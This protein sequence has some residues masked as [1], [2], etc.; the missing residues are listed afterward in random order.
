MSKYLLHIVLILFI[1]N[2]CGT[3]KVAQNSP[4]QISKKDYPYI[5]KFHEG[6]RLKTKGR[7]EEAI[8][9]FEECLTIRQ[10]D[11]AV[12]YALSKLEFSKGN[13]EQSANYIVKA[14]EID[15]DN[16]WYIQEL[17]YM[18]YETGNFEKSVAAFEQLVEIEPRNVD[19]QYGYAEA[20]VRVGKT[21]KAIDALNKT[22]DQVGANPQLAIQ[23]YQLYM[24]L[25]KPEK[26]VS[27]LS[28]ARK[29]FPKD[30]QLIAKLVDHYY[31][32]G[33]QQK[34]VDML[35]ELVLADPDNGRAHL[36]LADVYL[37]KKDMTKAYEQLE[38]AFHSSDIDL[39]TK[40]KILITILESSSKI[41]EPVYKLVD[42]LIQ[43]HPTEAKAHSIRGDYL[44]RAEKDEAALLSYKEALKYDNSQFPIWNQVLIMEYQANDYPAL[45]ADSKECLTLFPSISVVYLLNGVSSNQLDKY[46][47]AVDALSVGVEMVVK[48]KTLEAEFY[49][50]M[51]TAYFGLKDFG[52]GKKKYQKAMILDTRSTLIKSNYAYQLAKAKIDLEGAESLAKQAVLNSPKQAQFVDTYGFVLFQ[53][54]EFKDAKVKF[55]EAFDLENNNGEIA[56][57]L[58]DVEYKLGNNSQA[59]TWWNKAHDLGVET[60][61]LQKK[62]TEKKYYEE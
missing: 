56:E 28:E 25:K 34:A 30:A 3:K 22:E 50:Q 31:K 29:L 21:E 47:E 13:L 48:D 14:N 57:H 54:G 61:I 12:Y 55:K 1:A 58:G 11:D 16:T 18:F 59:L 39:D 60:P 5:T 8:A 45:Y 20:L 41:D 40:M 4:K 9:K 2:A 15:P 49:G 36:T 44:L 24:D 37:Q 52:T 27:E 10:D 51:G 7:K 62:I 46:E 23:K 32:Y 17:A 38:L 6:I 53:K 43:V 33:E 42:E 35:E 19:W 26:A